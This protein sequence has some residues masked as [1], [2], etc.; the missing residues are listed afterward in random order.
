MMIWNLEGK[1]WSVDLAHRGIANQRTNDSSNNLSD[2]VF[3]CCV[4]CYAVILGQETNINQ[5]L[6]IV[7]A[8]FTWPPLNG[9]LKMMATNRDVA[10]KMSGMCAY[11]LL[12][13]PSVSRAIP[14][15]SK[16]KMVAAGGDGISIDSLLLMVNLCG[17]SFGRS[18][19]LVYC[20]NGSSI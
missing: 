2:P 8:G 4:D 18:S 1:I 10:T 5:H 9:P 14:N 3:N 6:P 13:T 11:T 19:F 17:S 12:L 15:I 16:K 20:I 7:T